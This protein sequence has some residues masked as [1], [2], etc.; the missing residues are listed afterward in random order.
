MPH[1]LHCSCGPAVT[2]CFT[3]LYGRP[4]L[5]VVGLLVQRQVNGVVACLAEVS[6]RLIK[7]QERLVPGSN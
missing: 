3:E 7:K 5:S 1:L 6:C 4:K 2:F